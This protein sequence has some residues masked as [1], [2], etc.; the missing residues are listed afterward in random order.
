MQGVVFKDHNEIEFKL[1][2]FSS[3]FYKANKRSTVHHMTKA[4][5]KRTNI[6]VCIHFQKHLAPAAQKAGTKCTY[7]CPTTN[8]STCTLPSGKRIFQ[9]QSVC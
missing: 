8:T 9:W 1:V 3:A 4:S 6:P 7:T 2:C 5:R